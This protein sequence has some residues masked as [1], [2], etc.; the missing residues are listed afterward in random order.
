MSLRESTRTF[1][2][3]AP[4]ATIDV[5]MDKY[6]PNVNALAFTND[7]IGSI[8]AV[9]TSPNER[10]KIT[11]ELHGDVRLYD[12]NEDEEYRDEVPYHIL[13]LLKEGKNLA[14]HNIQVLNN[15]WFEFGLVRKH[16]KGHYYGE[17]IYGPDGVFFDLGSS[18]E[19]LAQ[20]L[21]EVYQELLNENA[22]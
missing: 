3:V 7:G 2:S 22:A 14:E 15:N 17:E 6:E 19:Q 4:A 5:F 8:F 16:E 1:V 20:Q 11:V 12:E 18:P 10:I 21:L 13:Q 9:L